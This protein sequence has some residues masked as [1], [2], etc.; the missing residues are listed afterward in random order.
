[1]GGTKPKPSR[2]LKADKRNTKRKNKKKRDKRPAKKLAS[3]TTRSTHLET[4]A[5]VRLLLLA[6]LLSWDH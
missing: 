1:L 6:L 5:R 4:F 3:Q 2:K